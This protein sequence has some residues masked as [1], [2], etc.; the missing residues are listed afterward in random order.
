MAWNQP[1]KGNQDPWRGKG[2]G[3]D[4]DAIFARIRDF[5]GG[6]GSGGGVLVWLVPLLMLLVLFNSFKLIDERQRG[7]VLRFGAFNRVMTP[8]ANFKWPWPIET[9]EIIDATKIETLEDTVRVLTKDE[10]IVDIKL[11]AQ[12]QVRDP[13]L[14]LYG[15]RDDEVLNG[16]RR[17]GSE[18]LRNAAESAV[19]EAVG[20]NTMDTVLFERDQLIVSAR[21]HLQDSLDRYKTGLKVTQFNLQDARPPE[22]VKPAFD[23][24][25]SARENKNSIINESRAYASKIVPEAL[26]A[27]ARIKAESEGYRAATIAKAEGDASRFQQ[28][29]AQYRKAPE[30]TRKRLYLETMQAVLASNTKV[31]AGRDNNILYLPI[32][33]AGGASSAPPVTKLPAVKAVSADPGAD[34]AGDVRPERPTGR[35]GSR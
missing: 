22:E 5:F 31:L 24:A 18:T 19:R 34:N 3:N 20:N 23:K 17:Q 30:V 10:N 35:E 12:Y 21:Q 27:A 11:N 8:G 13:R 1:G 25:I 26:G 16:E 14:F 9:A 6:G 7:V 28:L 32:N 29:V 33:A 15:F 2:S 4:M